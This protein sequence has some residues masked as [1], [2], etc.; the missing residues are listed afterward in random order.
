MPCRG[1]AIL[2]KDR[3]LPTP[4]TLKLLYLFSNSY[5][6]YSELR[7]DRARGGDCRAALPTVK[8]SFEALIAIDAWLR[9]ER[10]DRGRFGF[11][12]LLFGDVGKGMDALFS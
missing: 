8:Q 4:H 2:Q 12:V 5:R 1:G 3:H 7:R 10:G 11:A 9:V 6:K